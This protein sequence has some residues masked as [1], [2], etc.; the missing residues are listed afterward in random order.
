MRRSAPV[1]PP[2]LGQPLQLPEAGPDGL[3]SEQPKGLLQ[4]KISSRKRVGMTE[5]EQQERRGRP[6]PD[7]RNGCEQHLPGGDR[8]FRQAIK[9]EP[10][11]LH[12]R[13]CSLEA[14]D[15]G[16][17]QAA[18][19]ERGGIGVEQGLRGQRLERCRE[20]PGDGRGAGG[21]NLLADHHGRKPGESER[22][23]AKGDLAHPSC[24]GAH[25]GR[26]D[27]RKMRDRLLQIALVP[28]P[29]RWLYAWR[30]VRQGAVLRRPALPNHRGCGLI[31]APAFPIARTNATSVCRFAPSPN[32]DLHLGHAYS[33]LLNRRW[34][35][36]TGGVLLVRMEDIDRA[37][38]KP[39]FEAAILDDLRWLGITWQPPILR[40]SERFPLYE[41]ALDRLD[42]QGVLYPCFCT[43]GEIARSVAGMPD[44]PRDPDGTPL[45]PGTCR[46]LTAPER[47]ARREAGRSAA[48]RLDMQAARGRG[49]DLP[50]GWV[51]F[52]EADVSEWIEARP[53]RWGDVL[54]CRRDVP[55]SYHLSVVCDDEAQG[56]TDVVR[57]DDLRAA[58]SLHRLLQ[59]LL[60][61]REPAYHHHRLIRD[62]TGR[63]LSK[64]HGAP[65][66]R[67][68]RE[69]GVTSETLRRQLG[70]A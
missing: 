64:S 38:C 43:R 8:E 66:L 7:T 47:T 69:A 42:R 2:S 35:E 36:W 34:A 10:L 39:C 60:G 56:V 16:G 45:Y 57:G 55:T 49:L 22:R 61:Y 31:P 29:H 51:E 52:G 23:L 33:A 1:R 18:V 41:Q 15:L 17:G 32:G 65:A 21:G 59:V 30:C 63:K 50:L 44:W 25:H 6:G 27:C 3:V 46:R 68:L 70:F 28:Q 40:Q 11:V 9:V 5:P 4:R 58:T 24:H 14:A 20:S 19:P 53:E 13:G 54:L 67:S 26:I 48:L 12:G 37:R 62:E